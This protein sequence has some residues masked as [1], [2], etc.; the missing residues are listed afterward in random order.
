M[1]IGSFA[2]ADRAALRFATSTC[3]AFLSR[4]WELV[5]RSGLEFRAC[6]CKFLQVP[7][8]W[9]AWVGCSVCDRHYGW[10]LLAALRSSL[11]PSRTVSVDYDCR[12]SAS[13]CVCVCARV[14]KF[15]L[16][17]YCVEKLSHRRYGRPAAELFVLLVQIGLRQL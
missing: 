8:G 15:A 16:L 1:A 17:D 11:W 10:L 6:I 2:F 7:R 12:V 13:E 14:S 4:A 3:W 5:G 9:R